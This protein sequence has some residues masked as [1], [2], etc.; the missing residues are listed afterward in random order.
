MTR[1]SNVR[2]ENHVSWLISEINKKKKTLTAEVCYLL[3]AD[4]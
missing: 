2:L 3:L 4:Y 1:K